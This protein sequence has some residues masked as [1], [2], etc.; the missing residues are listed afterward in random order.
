MELAP[1]EH[2][3]FE[4]HPSWRATLGFYIKGLGIAIVLGGIAYLIAGAGLGIAVGGG[5]FALVVIIGFIKRLTT[6][7][8]IT[9]RR[10]HIKHGLI[11]QKQQETRVGSTTNVT[12]NQS[13]LE[14]MLGVGNLDFDTAGD[15][16]SDLFQFNGVAGPSSVTERVNQ[17]VLEHESDRSQG[18]NQ[19]T[20]T[21]G[22]NV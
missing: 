22:P 12:I 20:Q 9:N 16:R 15:G 13:A 8:T 10:L 7:Y 21:P 14:R 19:Q 18:F 5:I 4:G 1:G 11:A 3:L 2:T 17:A 6:T